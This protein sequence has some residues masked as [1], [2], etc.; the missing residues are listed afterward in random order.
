[1]PARCSAFTIPLNSRTCSPA[2]PGGGVLGVRGEEADRAVAPVV[3]QALVDQEVLVG[4]VVHRQQLDRGDAERRRWAIASSEARPGVGAAQVLAHA[5]VALGEALDVDLVDDGLVPGRR[6]AARSPS[7]SKRG[8]TTTDF[9]MASASSLVVGS[10]SASSPS[11]SYGSDVAGVRTGR[12]LDR[13]GVGVDQQLVRVEA[14]ALLGLPRAVDPVAVALAGADAGQVAVPVER[15]AL[16]HG[17]RA[18]RGPRRRTGTARRRS[19]FS[20][21]SEK[22]VPSPS[23]VAPSGNGRPGH[24]LAHRHRVA[25][26]RI[27]HPC[28]ADVGRHVHRP[29]ATSPSPRR[30][31][32]AVLL[33]GHRPDGSGRQLPAQGEQP[34][35]ELT[36]LGI[37]GRGVEHRAGE[38]RRVLGSGTSSPAKPAKAANSPPPPLAGGVGDG[39]VDVVGE[40]LERRVLAVLLAHEQH[41]DAGREQRAERGQAQLRGPAGGRRARGCRPG[42]GSGRTR[43]AASRPPARTRA[44]PRATVP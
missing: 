6:A 34:P 18:S 27:R 9:G 14:V 7:Q 37:A 38:R 41:R 13:L 44:P 11:G 5:R 39:R 26:P 19:A 4:D 12:A 20:E 31:A 10:R 29:V 24:T 43:R 1:M 32:T 40:E 36:E 28:C 15:G 35:V 23:Q 42:R 21:K 16:G 33:V 22:F 2:P 30:A 3:R 8:S 25:R 17:R